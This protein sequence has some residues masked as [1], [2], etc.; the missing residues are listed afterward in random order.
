MHKIEMQ[1][2]PQLRPA[3]AIPV[4]CRPNP[5]C[6]SLSRMNDLQAFLMQCENPSY[7]EQYMQLLEDCPLELMEEFENE[8]KR[9]SK[10]LACEEQHEYNV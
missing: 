3:E 5:H 1:K 4:N 9:R 8:L 6:T 10:W 2:Q 7:V